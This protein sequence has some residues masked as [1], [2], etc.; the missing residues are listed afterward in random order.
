MKP[1]DNFLRW[2]AEELRLLGLDT[3]ADGAYDTPTGPAPCTLADPRCQ[4]TIERLAECRARMR[5]MKMGLLDGRPVRPG[6]LA[7]TDVEATF[8][9]A[10]KPAT[11]RLRLAEIA[12]ALDGERAGMREGK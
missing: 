12:G 1:L 6:F 8:A 10:R 7:H 5:R 9:A 11:R 4:R 3:W 2:L